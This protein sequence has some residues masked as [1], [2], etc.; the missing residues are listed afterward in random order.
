M[1]N[2]LKFPDISLFQPVP[3]HE[4][5]EYRLWHVETVEM[6]AEC[7][8]NNRDRLRLGKVVSFKYPTIRDGGLG[9]GFWR[10]NYLRIAEEM[11]AEKWLVDIEE[12]EKEPAP[13]LQIRSH[14][15]KA[16]TST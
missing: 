7:L 1:T 9:L 12:G 14:M 8:K 13:Y 5:E 3:E 15:P 16:N 10:R 2:S 4:S 6:I 11:R